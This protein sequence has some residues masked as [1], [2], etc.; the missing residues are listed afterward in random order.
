[1]K[2]SNDVNGKIERITHKG[3]DRYYDADL[4]AEC[5][6]C[7]HEFLSTGEHPLHGINIDV[8]CQKCGETFNV[9]W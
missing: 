9:M 5:P 2:K 3:E 7:G 8:I 4:V 6:K 1:M